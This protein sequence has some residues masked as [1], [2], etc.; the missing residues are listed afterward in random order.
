MNESDGKQPLQE[1]SDRQS[2]GE[3]NEI[4][5]SKLMMDSGGSSLRDLR[6]TDLALTLNEADWKQQLDKG[7]SEHLA[8]FL[9]EPMMT[10]HHNNAQ[11]QQLLHEDA[12]RLSEQQLDTK[13]S[14]GISVG[15]GENDKMLTSGLNSSDDI[16]NQTP[17]ETSLDH[18]H[19]GVD[20]QQDYVNYLDSDSVDIDAGLPPD[21][22][23][24]DLFER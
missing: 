4:L 5:M 24:L 10:K 11:E 7:K 21:D 22:S 8:N 14:G 20:Q 2:L 18:H 19:R 17:R 6:D 3:K 16:G 12:S 1:G 9:N 15:H 13:Q 23:I